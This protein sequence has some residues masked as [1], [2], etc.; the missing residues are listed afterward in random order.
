VKIDVEGA[1]LAVLNGMRDNLQRGNIALMVEVTRNAV[2]VYDNLKNYGFQMYKSDKSSIDNA[3]KMGG[4]IF[5]VKAED[6]RRS[7]FL[8]QMRS[9]S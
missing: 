8:S 6:S 4:N 5:C 9:A 3:E 7:V 1:E 2:A